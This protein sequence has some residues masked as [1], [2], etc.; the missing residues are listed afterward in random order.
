METQSEIL[1]P[2]PRSVAPEP[3]R[4]ELS[5]VEAQIRRQQSDA[6]AGAKQEALDRMEQLRS[7]MLRT[8]EI[9]HSVQALFE[10][11][12]EVTR[13]EFHHF[14]QSALVRLPELQALEWIP[15]VS[16]IDR[17]RF[18]ARA[19]ADGFESFRFT[20]IDETGQLVPAP[21]R[22]EYC[23]VF[24]AEPIQANAPAL[25]LNL[26]ADPRRQEALE[27]AART[28]LP[29]ATSP[30]RLA[31]VT[32]DRLGFLVVMPVRAADAAVI[33]FGL[34]VFQIGNL[35][36]EIFAPLVRNGVRLEIFDNADPETLIY[37]AGP[38]KA[39]RPTWGYDQNLPLMGRVWH[40]RFTPGEAFGF[41]D[42]DWLRRSAETLKR[43]NE[44]LEQRVAERTEQ[45]AAL[46][47]ALQGEIEV[48]KQAEAAAASA[49]QAKSLFLAEMS[50]EIRT[51]LNIIL[52]YTQLLQRDRSLTSSQA[53]GMRAIIEGGN[54]LL[55]LVNGV[56][57]LTKIE[58][59]LMEM[60][61]V[62]FDLTTLVKALAAMFMPRCH[63][64]GLSFQLESLGSVPIWIR[65]DERKLR[66][67][68]VNLLGNAVKFT[69]FGEVRLRI[70][71]AVGANTF[72]F[73]VIDTGPGIPPLV[74]AEI[75]Q[76]FRQDSAG[77]SKGGTGLGLSIAR[78]FIELMG[79]SLELNSAPG[80]GSDFFFTLPFASAGSVFPSHSDESFAK[81]CLAKGSA[82]K[83]VVIERQKNHR[84]ILS[85]MLE[86]IGC[87][88]VSLESPS[89]AIDELAKVAADIALMDIN[90]AN[91]AESVS[92]EAFREAAGGQR[93]KFVGYSARAFEHERHQITA[94]GFDAILQKPFRF[95]QIS[96][97]LGRLLGTKFESAPAPAPQLEYADVADFQLPLEIQG[98]LSTAA[99][100]GDFAEMRRILADLDQLG[101][102]SAALA[103]Y[104]LVGV[105]RFDTEAV[106]SILAAKLAPAT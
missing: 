26:A 70:I 52:G 36:D 23:P 22:A 40:F 71:P 35:V 37:N 8:M 53:E 58:T 19:R 63:Q 91:G 39:A 97:C 67:I 33:G 41:V 15:R 55:C 10:V 51:P 81:L 59:G 13:A 72:R 75:F 7:D 76:P 69:D 95:E 1:S 25:G 82:I 89:E 50:H 61:V 99:E 20:E 44:I 14:V 73:E 45:L 77:H 90:I 65:G 85:K 34:A 98:R 18:E 3:T 57:D 79:G 43:T 66:Q 60:E 5:P 100:I 29:S 6:E 24:Y 80:W 78:R 32:G 27:R 87:T 31:Q 101:P 105:E 86:S 4:R 38:A 62:D 56:L 64:K 83:A 11:K 48:R 30:L 74:H 2:V 94:S 47:T 54:H 12:P 9:L 42:P 16:A 28:G 92:V 93:M 96:E 46:N 84:H 104:L 88:V 102:Q 103:R 21:R 68:L 49:N 17:E 106:R